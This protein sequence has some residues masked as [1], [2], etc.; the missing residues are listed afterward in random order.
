MASPRT[1]A[2]RKYAFLRSPASPN[3]LL[4]AD[5]RANPSAAFTSE[6]ADGIPVAKVTGADFRLARNFKPVPGFG[7]GHAER[8]AAA[9][10]GFVWDPRTDDF[11]AFDTTPDR[12]E[13]TALMLVV[14]LMAV[15]CIAMGFGLW[16][17]SAHLV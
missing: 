9:R 1:S 4:R 15:A 8:I 5:R 14:T 3:A 12:W 6:A 13:P 7:A 17:L 16:L 11:S 10:D 2:I